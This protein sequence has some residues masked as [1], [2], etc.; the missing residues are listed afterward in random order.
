ME[1]LATEGAGDCESRGASPSMLEA[2]GEDCIIVTFVISRATYALFCF[3]VRSM[4][5]GWEKMEDW[6]QM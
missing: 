3:F 1:R 4:L 5:L 6:K 2:E